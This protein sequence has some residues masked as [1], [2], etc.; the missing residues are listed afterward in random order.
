MNAKVQINRQDRGSD[1]HSETPSQQ[2]ARQVNAFVERTDSRGRLIRLKRPNAIA[3]LRFIEAM[4]ESSGNRLWVQVVAP[5]MNVVS[6][7]GVSNSIPISKSEI[8]ALYQRLDEDG[9]AAVVDGLEELLS[10]GDD[11][12]DAEAAK[13]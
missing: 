9:M 2:I 1:A 4:G 7:D 12:V 3:R 11:K 8:E 6:I 13:K 10:E 5:L